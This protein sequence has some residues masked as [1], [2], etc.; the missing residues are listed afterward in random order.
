MNKFK[1]VKYYEGSNIVIG[2]YMVAVSYGIFFL[3]MFSLSVGSTNT[4][5]P[6]SLVWIMVS[7]LSFLCYVT[8]ICCVM[9]HRVIHVY[10]PHAILKRTSHL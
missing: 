2:I 7:F 9:L 10:K 1:Y 3:I 6:S 4:G 8:V 5:I